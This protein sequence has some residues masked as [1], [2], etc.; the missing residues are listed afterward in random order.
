LKEKMKLLINLQDFDTRMG[1]ILAKKEEGPKKIER[2][3]QR[4]T[5]VEMELAEETRQIEAFTRN[6]RE[7]EQRIEDA[8][9]K[10]KKSNIK[11]SSIKSNKEYDAAMKEIDDLQKAKFLL[12]EKAIIMMEQLEALEANCAAGREKAA[13]MR[14]Q[15]EM[16]RD[17]VTRSIKALEQDLHAL[18]QERLGV[19]RAV[20]AGLLKRYDTLRERRGGIA[21]SPVIQGVCQTCHIRIPPQEFNELIRGDQ[22][23]SCP[24]CARIIYWGGDGQYASEEM[25]KSD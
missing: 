17:A 2:L 22:L 11:L 12:E 21:V 25:E 8:E 23:M 14:R 15:F 1:Y 5:D 7:M 6:R 10:L 9:N 4:L 24:H 3:E 19:S 20:D 13:E 18:Q 16:D